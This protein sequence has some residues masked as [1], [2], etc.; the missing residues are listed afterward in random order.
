MEHTM[1]STTGILIAAAMIAAAPA[2]FAKSDKAVAVLEARSD[3]AVKGKVTFVQKDGK[4]HMTVEVEGLTPG[5]HAIHLHEKGDCS[6][7]DAASAGGHW[8]PSAEN[9]GKW[10][11]DPFHHGDIGNLTADAKGKATLTF[12]TDL[13]TV[14]DGKP[15]DVVGRSVIVHAK[16]DDFTTQP[17]GNAGGRVACGVIQKSK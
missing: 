14:G 10:G 7:P 2:T 15:S 4:T 3:S 13:W 16:D 11:H 8:N 9:H 17:T 6:A 5:S 1:K 12:E